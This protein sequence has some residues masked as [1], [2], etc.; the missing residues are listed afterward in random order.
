LLYSLIGKRIKYLKNWKS[1]LTTITLVGGAF[2]I[3][4][5]FVTERGHW[6]FSDAHIIGLKIFGLPI[7]EILFFVVVPFSCLLIWEALN[8]FFK[9][10][11]VILFSNKIIY[12][13]GLIIIIL[14]WFLT[15]KEYTF[16]VLLITGLTLIVTKIKTNLF[17]QKNYYIFIAIVFILFI[18]F[19]YILTSIPIVIYNPETITN[20]RIT[21][22][23][24]ED[25]F[26]NFSLITL[27][28]IVYEKTKKLKVVRIN[29]K[30]IKEPFLEWSQKKDKKKY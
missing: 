21:T 14:L 24:I 18:I 15:S 16:I 23:P 4:D 13:L 9:K 5:I 6:S 11:E 26:Y 22:I 29:N 20:I 12:A 3:W 19:N 25:F 28:L 7:E 1:L 30:E 27:Y 2:I 8:Y 17:Q 10:K